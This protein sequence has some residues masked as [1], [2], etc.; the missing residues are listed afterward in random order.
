MQP[1][2]RD[3]PAFKKYIS[4]N[5]LK[6]LLEETEAVPGVPGLQVKRGLLKAF[7]KTETAESLGFVCQLYNEVKKDLS[8][9]LEKRRVDRNFIDSSTKTCGIRNEENERDYLSEEYETVIGKRDDRGELIVGPYSNMFSGKQK[10]APIPDSLS[11]KHVTLFGPAD[12]EKMSINAMNAWHRIPED[13][14]ELLRNLVD[15]SGIVPKWGA[16]DEDSK[17]PENSTFASACNNLIACF[18][19]TISFRDE[20]SLQEYQLASD[21][22]SLP[23]KRPPGLELPDGGH[24]YQG[25]PLPLHLYDFANHLFHCW[26]NPEALSFYIPK[27]ENEGEARY[28]KKMLTTAEEMI[29]K[30]HP[31]Y[32]PG[33][34]RLFIVFENPRAIFRMREIIQ[35]LYPYFAGG[36]LGWHDYLAS[37]ARLFRFDKNYRIPVKADPN[38][39]IDHIK[40]SHVLVAKTV[41]DHGGIGIGGMYGVLP[42]SGNAE[43]LQVAMVGFIKDV[44]TQMKRGL[45]GFWVAHPDFVRPGIALVEAW[46]RYA[47][48]NS[49][50]TLFQLVNELIEDVENQKILVDFIKGEDVKGLDGGD[51]LFPRALLA[52]NIRESNVIPNNHP[53]E[54]RYNVFQAL[55]YM[56]DWLCGNGCVA[57]P[58]MMKSVQGKEVFVRI[59]DDLATTERSRW[60]LWA[61]VYHKRFSLNDFLKIAYEEMHFIQKGK[62]SEIK[63]T[64]VK[65]NKQTEKWYPVALKILIQLVTDPDPVEFVS[66]LLLPFTFDSIR[67]SDDP[68]EKAYE[69]E[70]QKYTL[71]ENAREFCAYFQ[72]CGSSKYAEAMSQNHYNNVEE[73]LFQSRAKI[74]EFDI[75]DINSAADFHGTIGESSGTLNSVESKEQELVQG[76]EQEVKEE[77]LEKGSLY[78]KKFG[79]KFLI[80]ASGK[81]SEEIMQDL[82]RRLQNT[83]DEE[84][85]NAREAL[86]A[87]TEKRLKEQCGNPG[88]FRWLATK[89]TLDGLLEKHEVAGVNVTLLGKGKDGSCCIVRDFSAGYADK[90]NKIPMKSETFLQ[91]ASLSKTVAAA[92]A[93]EYFRKKEISLDTPVNDLL[94]ASGSPFQLQSAPGCPHEWASEVSL[95]HLLNHSAL[96]MHYVDGY[97]MEQERPDVFDILLGSLGNDPI[98]V[99]K[100]PG[101]EFHYSGGGFL[102]L[103]HL[104]E[105]IFSMP[106]ADI[107]RPFLDDLGMQNFS[108]RERGDKH[109]AVGYRDDGSLAAS[110]G[111]LLFP[112][113]AAGGEGTTGAMANFLLHL[114]NAYHSLD[115]SGPLSH[116]TAIQMLFVGR[117]LGS[118]DFMGAKMGLGVFLGEAGPNRIAVHQAANDGFRGLYLVCYKG[119]DMGKGFV[120]ASN[121]DHRATSLNCDI[122]RCLMQEREWRGTDFKS[123]KP[124]NIDQ[125]KQEEVVN[126]GIKEMLLAHLPLDVA[127]PIPFS[128]E[129]D[130][131]SPVNQACNATVDFCSNQRFARAENLFS[132]SIP[133][134]D[135]EAYGKNGKIMDSWESA[136]HNLED[137]DFV[138]F[139]LESS[140][141]FDLV[142]L[143]TM[144]H[145]G[146]HAEYTQLEAW[147]GEQWVDLLEK[148][149]LE[150]HCCHWFRIEKKPPGPWSRLRLRNYPDGGI[151]RLGLFCIDDLKPLVQD[152]QLG[153][154]LEGSDK[155]LI[156][157]Y[158]FSI[159]VQEEK[160]LQIPQL[161][162][163]PEIARKWQNFKVGDKVD[164]ACETMGGKVLEVSNE[165][166]GSASRILSQEIPLGMDDGFETK[167]NRGGGF[168]EIIFALGRPAPVEEIELDFTHFVNNTPINMDVSGLC[169]GEWT[170]LLPTTFVKPYRGNKFRRQVNGVGDRV[171]QVRVRVYPGGGFNRIKILCTADQELL[172]SEQEI[173]SLVMTN[174]VP[175]S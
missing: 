159:P 76:S 50:T 110:G 121:G 53:D 64:Q 136:R 74:L 169:E 161:V 102:L 141:S 173:Q 145:N 95:K 26:D 34:V 149:A 100:K 99:H 55:Q 139:T 107:M 108:F 165:H 33:S 124:L 31:D 44:V 52:A 18:H 15:E 144:Y 171:T 151:S 71:C 170:E 66:E 120:I 35:E 24:I 156:V 88:N 91:M 97:P 127:D 56:V 13:E 175:D 158:S 122:A 28:V 72:Q 162:D 11:G 143:S 154:F 164:V 30:R 10:I 83:Q 47:N 148:V 77:L 115:G 63:K 167:R 116:D 54:I 129:M 79:M 4:P 14:P 17:T 94:L 51:P 29:Q 67:E 2:Y 23:I 32:K 114:V 70:G 38:I 142:Q 48:D 174:Q 98:L 172:E 9:L 68:W 93:L 3:V 96:G 85:Q 78:H 163:E 105:A 45:D 166:Y 132:S 150:G 25:N 111:R 160:D 41:G 58:A 89:K 117:D 92:F 128:G 7:S 81:S 36:S 153:S 62:E 137:Y 82:D 152:Y 6:E 1:F 155:S 123:I 109:Y 126:I 12:T 87:I 157:P 19:G 86:I 112:E 119:P 43:S 46:G 125:L 134:F 113:L 16:D 147:D 57:L 37:T 73:L 131:F 103:Q 101:T 65:W 118:L 59:M 22:L 60:E 90:E 5:L 106:I 168:E 49:D 42:E 61:E 140:G 27:L 69:L 80:S 40:A 21:K 146:N 133:V 104:L 75:E 138:E 20:K 130:P 84:I 8:H 39:V 135:L